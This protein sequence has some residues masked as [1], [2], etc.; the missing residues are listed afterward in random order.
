MSVRPPGGGGVVL[1]A[2]RV[3]RVEGGRGGGGRGLE[4]AVV[5]VVSVDRGAVSVARRGGAVVREDLIVEAVEA[6][7]LAGQHTSATP[8][9]LEERGGRFRVRCA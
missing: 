5:D 1:P 4:A 6:S 3:R 8:G 9:R 2:R 7:G